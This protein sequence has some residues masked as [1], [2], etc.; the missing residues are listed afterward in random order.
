MILYEQA[1]NEEIRACL[2]IEQLIY[3]IKQYQAKPDD[4]HHRQTVANILGILIILNRSDIKLRLAK[5]LD[6]HINFLKMHLQSPN[7]DQTL[8]ANH[9][10]ELNDIKH[11]L[12]THQ[13]RLCHHLREHELLKQIAYHVTNIGGGFSFDTPAFHY[14]M[15]QPE[16]YRSKQIERWL[17][18][19]EFVETVVSTLLSITRNNMKMFQ[20]K[21][22]TGTYRKN[23]ES[24]SDYQLF[25]L[26]MASDVKAFPNIVVG[27]QFVIVHFCDATSADKLSSLY[28]RPVSFQLTCCA[29][30]KSLG[31]MTYS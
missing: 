1:A 12:L 18:E 10:H 22:E 4:S 13:G 20:E 29:I 19:F 15:S 26:E 8:L 7:V 11:K 27:K 5:R 25:R 6:Q 21:T 9:M 31:T 24:T 17:S 16:D 2:R 28:T 14:W 3:Q 30:P 23:L